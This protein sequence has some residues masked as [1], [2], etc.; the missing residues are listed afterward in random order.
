MNKYWVKKKP[1][2]QI[3]PP[4]WAQRLM[5]WYCRPSLLEDLQGDLN[6]YFD[7]NVKTKGPTRAKIIYVLDVLKFFRSYTVRK[8]EFLNLIIHWIMIGSYIKTSSRS[9]VRHK[10]FS[11]INIIGLAV[12]M[13]VG[14]VIIA[15]I[16]DLNS[17]DDFHAKKDRIYRIITTN[18]TMHLATT[19]VKAGKRIQETVSGI[20]ELTLLRRG[21]GGDVTVDKIV[22]PI[23]GL[24]AD[25]NFFKVFSFPFLQGDPATA[26]MEPYSL[27]LTER[28]AKRLFGMTDVLGRAVKFDTLDY[29]VTGILKD[30]PKRSHLQ[31][32]ALASFAT[33]ELQK[34]DTDG[35]FMNWESMYMNYVYVVLPPNSD[36]RNLQANLDKL[37]VEENKAID[38]AKIFLS[39]QPLTEI[40]LGKRLVN[41]IGP[42]MSSL[43][44]WILSGLG[45]VVILSACFNYTNLSIARSLRRSREVGIRKVIG[46][47]KSHV[48]GQFITESVII[49]MLSLILSFLLYLLL[50]SKFLSLHQFLG[51]LTTLSISPKLIAYFVILAFIVGIAGG[52]LPALFFSRLNAVRVLKDASSLTLFRYVNLRKS[53]IVLQYIFSL[54]LITTT[55]IG[56]KQYKSFLTYDLG[57]T[58]ENILNINV[59]GNK[60][61]LLK[62][63]LLKLPEIDK[64]SQSLIVMSL[65][66]I[67]G[68]QMKYKSL[69]DSASVWLNFIDEHYLPLHEHTLLAGKN[70]TP[71]HEKAE[72]NEAI[73]NEQTL[74][75]FNIGEKDPNRAVGE[76]ITIDGKQLTIVGVVKDFHYETLE[77]NIQP[78]VFRYFTN[79]SYGYVNAKI[80]SSDWPSTLAKVENVWKK[81]D[82]IH[83]LDAKFYHD[84]IEQAYSA[85]SMMIKVVGFLSFLAVC[86]AS[87]GLFGMVVFTTETRLKEISIRKVL[88]ASDGMLM[89]LLSK[90]F[91]ALLTIAAFIALPITYI[92]FN[93]VV[94]S[95]FAYHQPIGIGELLFGAGG[96]MLLAVL[97]IGSQTLKVARSNPADILRNE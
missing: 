59:Q 96:V 37:C 91:L 76:V 60:A 12:S 51:N 4:G 33:V 75:R 49:S 63:E 42:V 71:R 26:L 41:Q 52:I 10:L 64:V 82:K 1:E 23:G 13:S 83:P 30:I 11:T 95:S 56:Y 6:E 15:F 88:G 86:I 38:N 80:T 21:F 78:M 94:L 45:T 39:V 72:E 57:F 50:R 3:L 77:D 22:L 46:A 14:L 28:S 34:P 67:Y 32:E 53:L 2:K 90:G 47:S 93:S 16:F 31:F 40:V 55:I 35:G 85:F 92:F 24:W 17:F 62:N 70:F 81:M 48:L 89:Y 61:E 8:P 58:T 69:N 44:I 74:M 66:N 5:E 20:E 43:A 54:I 87:M 29:V 27:V 68:G 79:A 9:I 25:E 7:R 18:N 19:S 84:Q 65:G 97:M 36:P 73:V